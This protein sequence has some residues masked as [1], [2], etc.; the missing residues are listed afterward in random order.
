MNT[1]HAVT[2]TA[3]NASTYT[4]VSCS[5]NQ[6][7]GRPLS[8]RVSDLPVRRRR[9]LRLLAADDAVGFLEALLFLKLPAVHFVPDVQQF[10]TGAGE[11]RRGHRILVGLD[12][13]VEDRVEPLHVHVLRDRVV[14]DPLA[15]LRHVLVGQVQPPEGTT[16]LV[17]LLHYAQAADRHQLLAAQV[18]LA[19]VHEL[20]LR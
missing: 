13:E 3:S 5:T 1:T 14:L 7:M 8:P 17:V 6:R 19:R 18:E 9:G 12:A 10:L 15:D 2:A 16:L 20:L 4:Y 11:P